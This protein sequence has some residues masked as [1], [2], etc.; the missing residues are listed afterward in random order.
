MEASEHEFEAQNSDSRTSERE[1]CFLGKNIRIEQN[2]ELG[3]KT[4]C[5]TQFGL[6]NKNG[7]RTARLDL[8]F[9]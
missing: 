6:E 8:A 2:L 5:R 4:V 1:K 9:F 3:L 7:G